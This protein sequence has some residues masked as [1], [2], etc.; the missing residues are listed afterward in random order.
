MFAADIYSVYSS[1]YP[2]RPQ[3]DKIELLQPMW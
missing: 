3:L 1:Q 2:Q